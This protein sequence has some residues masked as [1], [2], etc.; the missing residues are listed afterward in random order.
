MKFRAK[1]ANKAYPRIPY[2][3][4]CH[5]LEDLRAKINYLLA[6]WEIIKTTDDLFFLRE[7]LN[8]PEFVNLLT[9]DTDI[10]E[11]IGKENAFCNIE[12]YKASWVSY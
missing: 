12:S 11:L 1:S 9:W 8:D 3:K 5:D 10:Y 4:R 6:R 7:E 2:L